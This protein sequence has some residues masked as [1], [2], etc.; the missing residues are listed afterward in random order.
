MYYEDLT[1][2]DYGY[3]EYKNAL[4]IGW[5]EKG[6][7]FLTGDFPEK[8]EV[9]K[10]LKAKKIENR[11]RGWHSCDYCDPYDESEPG[12][13]WIIKDRNGNGEYIVKWNGKTYAAPILITH[14]IEDH[15]YKPPQE[16]IDAVINES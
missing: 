12:H 4:N 2:Y 6:H 16:F 7:E 9:L 5:L 8:Q 13:T 11:Y 1:P 15:N 14:Y 3:T 10:K